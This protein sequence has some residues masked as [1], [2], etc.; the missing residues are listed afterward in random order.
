MSPLSKER[1]KQIRDE[2]REQIKKAALAA[3]ARHGFAGT[4]TSVIAAEAGISEGLI[5]R[6]YKSKDELY[7]EIVGE[8]LEAADAELRLLG[9]SPLSPFELIR[10]LTRN[11]LDENNRNAFRLVLQARRA[12]RVPD[13]VREMLARYSEDALIDRLVPVYVKGQQS[14]QFA[15]GDPRQTLAWYFTVVNS[16]ILQDPGAG[17]HG[18]PSPDMLMRML[19]GPAI[20]ARSRDPR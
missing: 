12:D 4:R 14:G 20:S 9:Q 18:L 7:A 6:Y 3:F 10:T 16:L 17:A 11:M 13:I 2:R 1:L 15:D 8:L 5:Y 19:A